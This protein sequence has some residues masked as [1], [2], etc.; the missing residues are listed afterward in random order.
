MEIRPAVPAD[1]ALILSFIRDLA[2]YEKLSHEVTAT[3]A[4]VRAKLFGAGPRVFCNIAE[5]DGEP[6]GFAVWFFNFSTFLGK[7]GLY[8]EDLFVRP[9][10]RGRGIGKALL[11]HLARHAVAEGCGRLEWWVLDWNAPAI[12]FY[13]SLG[14][15]PMSDWTV[16]RVAGGAL[17]R[18]AKA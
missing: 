13:K 3:E 17:E 2:A 18:L 4:E 11:V 7:H 16:F 12:D 9:Q 8:L 10:F 14:A 1:A 15:E 5:A 6:A